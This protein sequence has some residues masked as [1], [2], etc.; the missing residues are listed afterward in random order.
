MITQDRIS[1]LKVQEA[2][3]QEKLI[4]IQS[5]L[6]PH[7]EVLRHEL[8]ISKTLMSRDVNISNEEGQVDLA[9][10]LEI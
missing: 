7:M 9:T 5:M 1:E 10:T 4:S 2:N 3:I 6:M 8:S